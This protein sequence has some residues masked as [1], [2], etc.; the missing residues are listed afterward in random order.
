L[1]ILHRGAL[2]GRLD[3]KMLRKEQILHIKGLW[4]EAGVKV[5]ATLVRDLTRTLNDFARWQ[6]AAQIVVDDI[7]AELRADWGRGWR[8]E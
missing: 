1:P 7:P 5:S 8:C 3:A 4:L 6:G 2:K